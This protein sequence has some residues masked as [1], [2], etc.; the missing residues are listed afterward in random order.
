MPQYVIDQTVL[1][2]PRDSMLVDTNV[3]VA[4][5]LP[6]ED[7]DR[8][9]Y[10]TYI[11]E[12]N[13]RPLL[14]PMAVVVE[15]LGFIIGSRRN[16]GAGLFLLAWLNTP[17]RATLVP[18]HSVELGETHRLMNRHSVDCVD[19][20]LVEL[21]T[22]I[23]NVCLLRPAMPIATWDSDFARMSQRD[24]VKLSI[25]NPEDQEEYEIG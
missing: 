9:Y 18:N 7:A 8:H 11:L 16:F 25:F 13:G 24:G 10:A 23:T 21:A 15:A 1:E 22:D 5:F 14:V 12:E 2:I 19:A 4:A 17:G 3:L 20:M 6:G